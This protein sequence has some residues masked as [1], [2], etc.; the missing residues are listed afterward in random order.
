MMGIGGQHKSAQV[1]IS[2]GITCSILDLTCHLAMI[3]TGDT[4]RGVSPFK[5]TDIKVTSDPV[6][7]E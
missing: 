6:L 5:P 7:L 4:K 3:S 1:S 2:R